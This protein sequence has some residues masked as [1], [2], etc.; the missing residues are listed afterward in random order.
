MEPTQLAAVLAAAVLL[1][2]M[3]SVELGIV[4]RLRLGWDFQASLIAGKALS[5]TSPCRRLLGAGR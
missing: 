4:A 3:V 1:A 2:S 5:T